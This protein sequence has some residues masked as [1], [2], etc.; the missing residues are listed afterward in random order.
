MEKGL[1]NLVMLVT[2][3]GI[4]GTYSDF[5]L[6]DGSINYFNNYLK[7]TFQYTLI[8]NIGT[9]RIRICYNKPYYDISSSKMGSKMLRSLDSIYLEEDIWHIRIYYI[10]PSAV[11]IVLTSAERAG[12]VI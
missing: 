10:D 8:D 12:G 5:N 11:E 6:K 3:S 9:G 4:P 1:V 7:Q 2:S